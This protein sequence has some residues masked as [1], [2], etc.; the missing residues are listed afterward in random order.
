MSVITSII[1]KMKKLDESDMLFVFGFSESFE[2]KLMG[3]YLGLEHL[4]EI[5][6]PK[7]SLNCWKENE[8]LGQLMGKVTYLCLNLCLNRKV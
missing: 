8:L 2:N 1:E 6:L 3:V 4:S 5:S 7:D